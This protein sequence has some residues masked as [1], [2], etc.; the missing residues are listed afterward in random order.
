[1]IPAG[2]FVAEVGSFNEDMFVILVRESAV[3]LVVPVIVEKIV[4]V[5]VVVEEVEG[6][7]ELDL[8]VVAVVVVKVVVVIVEEAEEQFDDD[9]A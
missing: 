1:M 9:T 6:E 8:V 2:D 3:V 5:V 7:L 4:G